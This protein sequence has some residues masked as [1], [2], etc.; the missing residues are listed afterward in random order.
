D[1]D[2]LVE[3]IRII[4][5]ESEIRY[6]RQAAAVSEI[7]QRAAWAVLKPGVTEAEVAATV[8]AA[9]VRAGCEYTGLPHHIYSGHRFNVNHANGG[10]KVIAKGEIVAMELYGC[11]ERYHATQMRTVSLGPLTHERRKIAELLVSAQDAQI[12]AMKP[13]ASSREVDALVRKP[14]RKLRPDYYNRS[15]YSTGIGFPPKSGEWETLD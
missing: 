15:G 1:T 6:L 9:G 13:G 14:V 5:S 10:L 2:Q 7:E 8:F 11:V 4:K 12:A 3:R